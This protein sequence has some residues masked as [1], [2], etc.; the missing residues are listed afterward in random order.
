MAMAQAPVLAQR[1]PWRTAVAVPRSL[2]RLRAPRGSALLFGLLAA[3]GPL[4]MGRAGLC[5][6]HAFP[7]RLKVLF[8]LL[9]SGGRQLDD[10]TFL[11]IVV[12]DVVLGCVLVVHVSIGDA[13]RES[14]T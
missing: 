11:R 6:G 4:R 14:A 9:F 7:S 5:A 12:C 3:S 8:E 2:G 1:R 10:F 13:V